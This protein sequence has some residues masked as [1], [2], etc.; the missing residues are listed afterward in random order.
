MS[1]ALYP[2]T[3]DPL[4]NG[5]LDVIGVASRVFS[6]LVVAVSVGRPA[7]L[8][9]AEQ[10]QQMLE[11]VCQEIINVQVA[12]YD[13]LTVNFAKQLKTTVIVRGVRSAID[14]QQER[15]MAITNSNLAPE[16]PTLLIMPSP[17]F[18]H[19]SSTLVKEISGLGGDIGGLVPA[20]VAQIMSKCRGVHS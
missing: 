6:K 14:Y 16:I 19:I 12:T 18:S 4:T 20:N 1:I 3:F 7:T 11:D 9:S 13:G 10:R 2:G 8:F 17:Q 5:H 15:N